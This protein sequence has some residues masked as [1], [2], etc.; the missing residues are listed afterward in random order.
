MRWTVLSNHNPIL[1]PTLRATFSSQKASLNIAKEDASSKVAPP[2]QSSAAPAP[3]N[4]S[5]PTFSF[6]DLG[7]NRG[8]KV[9][10]VVCLTVLGTMESI[11]W[12]KVLWAKISPSPGEASKSGE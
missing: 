7:A 3:Q 11:F 6:K 10:V 1:S 9:V 4:P 12:G 2:K 8:V 5:Y